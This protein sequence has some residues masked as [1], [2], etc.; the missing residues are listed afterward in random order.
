MVFYWDKSSL[1]SGVCEECTECGVQTLRNEWMIRL[2]HF[3]AAKVFLLVSV[4]LTNMM[5]E[6]V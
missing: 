6:A 2:T 1:F 5:N 4:I 3:K